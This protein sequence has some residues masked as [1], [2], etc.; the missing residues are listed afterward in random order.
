MQKRMTASIIIFLFLF[1]IHSISW[2]EILVSENFNDRSYNSPLTYYNITAYNEGLVWDA[3]NAIGGSGYCLRWDHTDGMAGV[4][5]LENFSQNVGQG[6]YI[7]YWVKYDQNYTFPAE[8]GDFENLKLFK[9]ASGGGL[10]SYD[11][12]FIYKNTGNGGPSSLQLFW[13]T[14][15]GTTANSGTGT[16]NVPLGQTIGKGNWHK[17]EIYIRISTP[18]IVH[19]QV[20]DIDVYNNNNADIRLPATA[21][22]GSQQFQSIRAGSRTAAGHGYW[23]TD[24]VTVIAN[25]GDLCNLEPA[26]PGNTSG[27]SSSSSSSSSSG[28]TSAPSNPAKMSVVSW[29]ANSETGDDT[30][31]DSTAVWCARVLVNSDSIQYDGDNIILTFQGR[32]SG[33]YTIRKVSIAEKDD[34]DQDG[35]IVNNTWK[36]VTFDNRTES[37]WGTDSIAVPAGQVKRS[38]PIPFNFERGK[39]YYVTFMMVSPTSYLVAPSSYGELY[40]NGVDHTEDLDWGGNGHSVYAGRLH[41]LGQ[42]AVK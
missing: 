42:I 25:E 28:G 5:I 17:I 39:N 29:S 23:Y 7:R 32:N 11:I 15:D 13:F 9:L 24:N 3:A 34:N 19:V 14:S 36:M 38:N 27:G 33:S 8:Q 30:W 2:G 31:A 12:E 21:Y 41:A 1:G 10:T 20:N 35:N 4:G 26:E 40:F 16:G 37:T 6:V 22:T 18:S